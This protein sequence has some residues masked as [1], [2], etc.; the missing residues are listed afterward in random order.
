[1]RRLV[2]LAFL[3]LVLPSFS[4]AWTYDE[5][6]LNGC[7]CYYSC[8]AL[9]G[10]DCASVSCSYHPEASDAS[11]ACLN[12][13]GGPC[14][15]AGWGC[16]RTQ[17]LTSGA[18]FDSCM[19]QQGKPVCGDNYCDTQKEENCKTCAKDCGCGDH[20]ACGA[21]GTADEKGCVDKCDGVSCQSKCVGSKLLTAGKCDRASKTCKYQEFDCKAGC[22][23]SS[24]GGARCK[25]EEDKCKGVVCDGECG[26][27]TLK[28]EG[29]CDPKTGQ[30]EYEKNA[31]CPAGCTNDKKCV[32][33]INGEVYYTETRYKAAG[34]KVP[35]RNV[36]VFFEY[37]DK[38]GNT[39]EPK[40]ENDPE[41]TVWT[42]NY[43]RFS[44]KYYD[45]F[46][47]EG[48]ISAG[49]YFTNRDKKLFLTE[50]ADGVKVIKVYYDQDVEVTDKNLSYYAMDLTKT[51]L[52]GNDEL[53]DLGRAYHWVLKAVEFKENDLRKGQTVKER[54]M[55]GGNTAYAWHRGE[56][57]EDTHPHKTGLNIPDTFIGFDTPSAPTNV[58]F[59]EYGHHIMDETFNEKRNTPGDDHGGNP[60]NPT[61]EYG[62][63]EAWAEYSALMMK[64]SNG[65]PKLGEY[66]VQNTIFDFE[67]NYKMDGNE[68][69]EYTEEMAIAGIML[70]IGDAYSDY[71]HADDDP[72]F[73]WPFEVY[74]AAHGKRDFGDGKGVR[75]P[76]T[77]R[78]FYLAMNASGRPEL[79]APYAGNSNLTNLDYVFVLHGAFQDKNDN[80]AWDPGET[81]GYSGKRNTLRED[82][83]AVPGLAVAVDARDQS[84]NAVPNA[85]AR[86]E[87]NYSGRYAYMSRVETIPLTDGTVAI[88]A[89]PPEYNATYTVSVFQGGTNNSGRE[90]FSITGPELKK[91]FKADKQLGTLKTTIKT[92][93]VPCGSDTE[94]M[95]WL[96]GD[97]CDNKTKTCRGKAG[98]EAPSEIGCGKGLVCEHKGKGVLGGLLG[99]KSGGLPCVSWLGLIPLALAGALSQSA[100]KIFGG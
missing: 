94:C 97:S 21:N 46:D 63:I 6:A 99:G 83:A 56:K 74:E 88:P 15:C 11:P 44:W 37:T 4:A 76:R 78:D 86:L 53:K 61:S 5:K 29:K 39:F 75:V 57:Y 17:M 64:R 93:P 9:G 85:Y 40:D 51:P 77:V 31:T 23:N 55:I 52:A 27:N 12:T 43:G 48:L 100:W 60:H 54:V 1:M 36:R 3:A 67:V 95:Y 13:G 38:D 58:E 33:Q 91:T 62:V 47:P 19:R 82:L 42:D 92:T 79:H 26:W 35:L 71:G 2:V 7:L 30:C 69:G 68:N 22:D 25:P 90:R 18:S 98:I 84:G 16:G 14:M 66:E 34:E 45:N 28:F 72:L 10:W 96:A 89:V 41:F 87:V 59:H 65:L 70:D 50:L 73:V 24:W 32:G 80:K 49:V 20:A 8:G 81:M